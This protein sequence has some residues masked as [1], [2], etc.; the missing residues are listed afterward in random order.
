MS[1]RL[2][3]VRSNASLQQ[4]WI[5]RVL[6][7]IV[8]L[9]VIG[10]I[11]VIVSIIFTAL[12]FPVSI[13]SFD[14]FTG[15]SA[16]VSTI[17]SPLIVYGYYTFFEGSF[18]ATIGKMFLGLRVLPI[19]GGTMNYKKALVRNLTKPWNLVIALAFLLDLLVGFATEGDPRERFMDTLAGTVVVTQL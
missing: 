2:E 7:F 10:I 17:L 3:A 12:L 5:K 6:A 16:G 18:N 19:R 15:L 13:A 1:D 8:D 4:L 14:I 11:F 9:I